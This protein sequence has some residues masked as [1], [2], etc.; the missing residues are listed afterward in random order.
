MLAKEQHQSVALG[1][2]HLSGM[3]M[4]TARLLVFAYRFTL[5]T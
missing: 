2:Q 5:G 4:R 1:D 3:T